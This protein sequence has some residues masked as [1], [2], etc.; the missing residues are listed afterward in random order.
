MESELKKVFFTGRQKVFDGNGILFPYYES[1]NRALVAKGYILV[2]DYN[3][4][5]LIMMDHSTK[6]LKKWSPTSPKGSQSI[7]IQME[8]DQVSPEQNKHEIYNLY[9][10]II[11]IGRIRSGNFQNETFNYVNFPYLPM[12]AA[13]PTKD[14]N[15]SKYIGYNPYSISSW[16]T[17]PINISFIAMNKFAN[18]DSNLYHLRR[19]IVKKY[20]SAD[21]KVY[22]KFWN[23]FSKE[24]ITNRAGFIKNSLVNKYNPQ[25]I[26]ILKDLFAVYPKNIDSVVNKFQVLLKSR[27]HLIVEN[28]TTTITEKL[29]DAIWAG[30]IPIYVGPSLNEFKL[31]NNLAI[32]VDSKDIMHNLHQITSSNKDEAKILEAGEAFITSN[33]FIREWSHES[34]FHKIS[35]KCVQVFKNY[36]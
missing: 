3:A 18:G 21:L 13:N 26:E 35:E 11:R 31:P 12:F 5:Y 22:G 30:C 1:M 19:K 4:E 33:L 23:G 28:S 20:G 14:F 29:F 15:H 27:Y 10:A 2:D 6:Q 8:T 32:E 9:G 34:V 16:A 7:L 36:N 24:T 25:F 17:R